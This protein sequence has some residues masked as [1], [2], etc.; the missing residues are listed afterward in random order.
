MF[1]TF[2]VFYSGCYPKDGL[3]GFFFHHVEQRFCSDISK[4]KRR[5]KRI[6]SA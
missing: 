5:E 3:Q 1:Y 2:S 6:C 4:K